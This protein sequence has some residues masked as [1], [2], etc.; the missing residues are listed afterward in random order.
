MRKL[1]FLS[2]LAWVACPLLAANTITTVEQVTNAVT[3]SDDVDYHITSTTPF[4][5]TGSIDIT[6][7]EHAVVIIDNLRPSLAAKQLGFIT[8][9]GEKAVNGNNCQVKMYNNGAIIMPYPSTLKP[10]TVFSEENFAGESCNDFGLENSGGYMNTLSAAK[11][12]N[13]IKSFKLKRGYMV[14]FAIGTGGRGYSRCFIADH[15]D[16]E[17]ATLPA[18]L[19]GRISSYRVFK[20]NNFSKKGLASDTR[21]DATQALNVQGCYSWGLGEDRGM[22][23][24]CVPNHI[25]EDWPSSAACGGVTYS[26]HMKTNNEP[27]NSADD[28]PQSVETVLNNWQNLMRTGM[29]LCSPSSHDGSLGWLREFLDS[30]DARGWRCDLL[31]MHCYWPEGSFGNLAG[32]YNSYKRPIWVSEFVWGA[33]WNSNGAFASGVTEEDNKNAMS[34]ILTRLNQW[35]YVERYFYWNSERDPSKIYKNSGLTP[36]GEFYRDMN[37][38]LG[39][40]EDLQYVPRPTRMSSPTD[41]TIAFNPSTTIATLKWNDANGELNDSMLV[42]RKSGKGPWQ[43]IGRVAVLDDAASYSFKDTVSAAGNYSYRIHTIAYSKTSRYS[44]EVYNL[45]SGSEASGNG[46]V[47]FGTY[48]AVSTADSYN[49][50]AAPYEEQPAIVFGSVSNL[51]ARLALVERVYRVFQQNVGGRRAY[52]FYRANMQALPLFD[53][54]EFYNTSSPEVSSYIVAKAGRGMV[55]SLPYEA[56]NIAAVNVGDTATYTFSEPFEDTPVVMATPIYTS[57]QYPLLWRVFDVTPTGFKV[58][59][60]RQKDYDTQGKT[61]INADISFYAIAKGTTSDGTGRQYTVRDTVLSFTNTTSLR[62]VEYGFSIDEPAVLVQMQTLNKDIA[63]LLRTRPLGP[64]N[65]NTRIRL[66]VDNTNKDV[67]ISSKDP[68]TERIGMIIIGKDPVYDAINTLATD[69][70]Q[71]KLTVYPAVAH[72]TLG[73]RDDAATTVR[74]YNMGG[75]Q[76]YSGTLQDG[77]STINVAALPTGIYIVRTNAGHSMKVVKK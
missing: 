50:F 34:R 55:G 71:G 51:N 13:R 2:L 45:I 11:L 10:L 68:A 39:Y 37:T 22:D 17:M 59:L 38:G 29:R 56:G 30:I 16:L 74:L 42:E 15:A 35:E 63:A 48:N 66:Q 76:V 46:D 58:V 23:C 28:T 64:E 5:T 19:S 75:Q 70:R 27:G 3:L 18:I 41:L 60:Q 47:Q 1:L 12:N 26:P 32:W 40:R 62:K 4:T 54:A 36:L 44:A 52:S 21:Y 8:I 33:S 20:W 9:N 31:D 73:V 67:T 14:T 53:E 65:D 77:Q 7:T 57:T 6:N 61:R 72:E 24:E 25:Y 69:G 43:V 49:Y